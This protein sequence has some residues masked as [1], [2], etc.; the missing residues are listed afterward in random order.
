MSLEVQLSLGRGDHFRLEAA[1]RLPVQ[2]VTAL[3]G[4]SG[5]GKS[6]LL[7][8]LAGLEPGARGEV[9]FN[10]LPW[11]GRDGSWIPPHRRGVGVVF[12]EPRLFPHLTVRENLAFGW[13][14]RPPAERRIPWEE[15]VGMLGIGAL[16]DRP[17]RRLS[18]GERQRVALGRALL[19]SPRLLLLDEPTAALDQANKRRILAY[20][21]ELTARHG[22]PCLVVSHDLGEVL[23]VADWL[24]WMAGGRLTQ[25]GE[26]CPMLTRLDLPLAHGAEA[27]ALVEARV[28]DREAEYHLL[29]LRLGSNGEG[30]SLLVP[31]PPGEEVATGSRVR[32]RILA[33]DVSLTL[34][35]PEA[36][37]ILNLLP[38][39]VEE[40]GEENPAQVVVKVGV[41][42]VSL[43]A[44]IT[45]KSRD[46]LGI[47]PGQRLLAQVKSVALDQGG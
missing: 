26:V 23:P 45:R 41:A 36:T 9:R 44:R 43:L 11:Q 32:V 3:T 42:G 38:A 20:L 22:L 1:I 24:A 19:A 15:V 2:G 10:G 27:G 33:K 30:A 18:G 21:R 37:S 14:R 31:E 7:R 39:V 28:V 34:H 40:I 17:P 35:R 47:T 13:S 46:A 5:A 25:V 4:P 29:R 16:L 8:C 12:Q 6:T